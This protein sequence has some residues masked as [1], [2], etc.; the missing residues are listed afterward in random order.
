MA[1][2]ATRRGNVNARRC[3][4]TVG[5]VDRVIV[6]VLILSPTDEAAPVGGFVTQQFARERT[7]LKG[8]FAIVVDETGD[9][10]GIGA[11]A[12]SVAVDADAADNVLDE[13]PR[14][15]GFVGEAGIELFGTVDAAVDDEVPNGCI[16]DAIER[17]I[18]LVA[19]LIRAAEG[20]CQRMSATVEGA[21]EGMAIAAR[22]GRGRHIGGHGHRLAGIVAA[23][24]DGV[25]EVVPV[26]SRGNLY[27]VCPFPCVDNRIATRHSQR[28]GVRRA[29]ERAAAGIVAYLVGR[30]GGA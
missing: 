20:E 22:H 12:V 21:P 23:N 28:I 19:V 26:F 7:A 4:E 3:K 24:P 15:S 6:I 16:L 25:A 18:R 5:K 9:E 11:V 2:A 27:G 13:V 29:C 8:H 10:A 14:A 1:V 17:S 30:N